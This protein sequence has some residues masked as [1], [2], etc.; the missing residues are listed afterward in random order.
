MGVRA[1]EA[2]AA[3]GYDVVKVSDEAK[4][5]KGLS[6]VTKTMVATA[7]VLLS[8]LSTTTKSCLASWKHTSLMA[9]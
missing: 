3:V 8:R 6:G 2:Y 7:S 4:P 9:R 5:F 1:V